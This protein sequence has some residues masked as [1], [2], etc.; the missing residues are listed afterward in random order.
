MTR[1]AF[2]HDITAAILVFLNND[3]LSLGKKIHFL[4]WGNT[5]IAVIETLYNRIDLYIIMLLDLI[6]I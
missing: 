1:R 3:L 4:F 2:S 6:F 5:N